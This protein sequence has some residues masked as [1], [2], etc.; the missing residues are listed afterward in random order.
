MTCRVPLQA[1]AIQGRRHA[2]T[3]IQSVHRGRAG[4]EAALRR[5]L[6]DSMPIIERMQY[7]EYEMTRGNVAG[8]EAELLA[9]EQTMLVQAREATQLPTLEQLNTRLSSLAARRPPINVSPLSYIGL[10][11]YIIC[12]LADP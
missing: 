5:R 7:V 3:R 8:A 1:S 4:R 12:M 9:I 2:A 6:L 11:A 10:T